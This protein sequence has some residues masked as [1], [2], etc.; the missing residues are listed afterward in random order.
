MI[1]LE[2]SKL[3][4]KLAWVKGQVPL[5]VG[6]WNQQVQA[7]KFQFHHNAK[8]GRPSR[9]AWSQQVGALK[10]EATIVKRGAVQIRVVWDTAMPCRD[11][12]VSEFPS[13]APCR[14]Q[15]SLQRCRRRR[16]GRTW[17]SSGVRCGDVG[18]GELR[19]VG[20][21][22]EVHGPAARA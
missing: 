20:N 15:D 8:Y 3:Q 1:P 14:L 6:S 10:C 9:L 4:A 7:C 11:M 19:D 22:G 21:A 13:L 2:P 5:E 12:S 18:G 17:A 16:N